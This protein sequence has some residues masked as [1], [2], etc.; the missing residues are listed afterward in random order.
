[1]KVLLLGD[2]HCRRDWFAWLLT[3]TPSWDLIAMPG[4]LLDCFGEEYPLQQRAV[5][6]WLDELA[7]RGRPVAWCSGN[8]DQ[9]R[10][11]FVGENAEERPCWT[12]QLQG[13]AIVGDLE[14]NSI[15]VQ[16][17]PLLVS[18]LPYSDLRTERFE[19]RI[20]TL[21]AD[22]A[23][24]RTTLGCPWIVLSHVPPSELSL[25]K[26][27]RKDLG[28]PVLRYYVEKYRPDIVLSGHVHEAPF[29]GPFCERIGSTACFNA[30]FVPDASFPCHVVLDLATRKAIFHYERENRIQCEE[31]SF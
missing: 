18:C 2:L 15:L 19:S 27:L 16:G 20:G 17:R 12:D 10:W 6:I 11:T 5:T 4:D 23:A 13:S 28:D 29:H 14:T 1:M 25:S 9:G 8:H 24:E 7:G 3:Q 30:G 21:L 22:A 31:A 26:G